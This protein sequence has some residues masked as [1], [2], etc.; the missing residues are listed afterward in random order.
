MG[1]PQLTVVCWANLLLRG[2]EILLI[3]LNIKQCIVI[4]LPSEEISAYLCNLENLVDWSSIV[5]SVRNGSSEKP[6]VGATA[7]ST[8]RFLGKWFTITFEIVEYKPSRFLTIKSISGIAPCLFCYQFEEIEDGG[9]TVSQD[10]LIQLIEEPSDVAAPV[11]T[12]AL[13]RQLTHDL[14]TLKDMLE[15][16]AAQYK[17]VRN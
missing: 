6:S 17:N 10:V 5:I 4:N 13:R 1:K 16:S 7:R 2:E 14:L 12:N 9:T 11:V 15:A 8:I 3:Q